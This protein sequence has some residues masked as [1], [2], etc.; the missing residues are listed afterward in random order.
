MD[1]LLSLGFALCNILINKLD[2]IYFP[3]QFQHLQLSFK[4][5]VHINLK[6]FHLSFN[7]FFLGALLVELVFPKP[8]SPPVATTNLSL[9]FVKS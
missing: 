5:G 7:V 2:L 1:N 6:T 4:V 9:S 8:P 3:V